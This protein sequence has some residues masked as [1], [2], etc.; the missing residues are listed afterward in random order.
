MPIVFRKVMYECE[1]VKVSLLWL[2]RLLRLR[3]LKVLPRSCHS[4]LR[5]LAEKRCKDRNAESCCNEKNRSKSNQKL[6]SYHVYIYICIYIY[7]LYICIIY[8]IF[9]YLFI[10]LFICFYLFMHFHPFQA[11]T[12]QCSMAPRLRLFRPPRRRDLPRRTGSLQKGSPK[13]V[14]NLKGCKECYN[15]QRIDTGDKR[16]A[17]WSC[18]AAP[19][20]QE[21]HHRPPGSAKEVDSTDVVNVIAIFNKPAFTT[22]L[23]QYLD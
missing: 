13:S 23:W 15:H 16:V 20:P 9:I 5:F 3:L 14:E 2:L 17:T 4:T 7:V 19:D 21:H 11:A 10:H 8:L 22:H 12:V 18:H 6:I 1:P